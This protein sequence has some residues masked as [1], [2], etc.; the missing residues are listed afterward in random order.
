MTTIIRFILSLFVVLLVLVC[1]IGCG[2]G[3]SKSETVARVD[4]VALTKQAL[5]YWMTTLFWG[6]DYRGGS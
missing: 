6:R 1:L 3:G 4:N 5:A 2:G